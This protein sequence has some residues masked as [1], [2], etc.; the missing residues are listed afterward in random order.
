MLFEKQV[1]NTYKKMMFTRCDDV[2]TVFYFS[3][4][5]FSGLNYVP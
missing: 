5:D 2:K 4:E 3:P 1:V